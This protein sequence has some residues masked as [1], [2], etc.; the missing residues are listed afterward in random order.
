MIILIGFIIT[1]VFVLVIVSFL[2]G[3]ILGD[4]AAGKR[5]SNQ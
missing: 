1:K 2:I 3:L 5:R 4:S